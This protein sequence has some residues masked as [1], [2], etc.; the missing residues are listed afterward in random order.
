MSAR[1]VLLRLIPSWGS[2]VGGDAPIPAWPA[3]KVIPMS[4]PILRVQAALTRRDLVLLGWLADHGVLTT[5]QIAAA[6][7]PSVN[8]AQ[9]RLRALL[10]M[11]VVDRFR[12]QRPD[13]GSYPYHWLLAQLGTDVV[14]SQRGEPV[15]RRDQARQRRWQLTSRANL[16]H[17]LGVNEF[18]TQL[19]AHARTHPEAELRRWWAAARCQQAGAF[20]SHLRSDG[21]VDAVALAYRPKVRPDGHGIFTA[22][23]ATTA[24]FLEY[25]TGTDPLGRLVEKVDGYHDLARVTGHLWP[26]LFWV[27]TPA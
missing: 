13:G 7:F 23:N 21:R 1:V 22:G 27:P 2:P 6:L 10:S 15:P 11:R 18:F 24:F 3:A 12:P 17:L 4:E 16:P 25:D 8:F 5:E 26:V 9:R 19:A 20:S 14:A